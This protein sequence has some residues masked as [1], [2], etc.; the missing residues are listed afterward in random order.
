MCITIHGSENGNNVGV[1]CGESDRRLEKMKT[2][3]TA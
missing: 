3:G 2:R 1:A